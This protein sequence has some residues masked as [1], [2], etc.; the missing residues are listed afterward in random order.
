MLELKNIR[1][2]TLVE[3]LVV[4]AIIAILASMLLPALGKALERGKQAKC[5]NN[6]KQ[7]GIVHAIYLDDNNEYFF[8][9]HINGYRWWNDR[10]SNFLRSYLGLQYKVDGAGN[11]INW[12]KDSVLDCPSNVDSL[13]TT[14]S[15]NYM[16]NRSAAAFGAYAWNRYGKVKTPSQTTLFMGG[17]KLAMWYYISSWNCDQN[18]W[19]P[20]V[21][22]NVHSKN[23]NALLMDGHVDSVNMSTSKNYVNCPDDE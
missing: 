1:K 12:T 7:I 20:G 23:S 17:G 2:F 13:D 14:I 10:T 22:T 9:S 19:K 16:H 15:V 18:P 8:A 11:A 21:L 4:I 6:L 5:S 3:L